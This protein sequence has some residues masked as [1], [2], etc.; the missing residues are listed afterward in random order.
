M[1]IKM[2]LKNLIKERNKTMYSLSKETNIPYSTINDYCNEK[3]DLKKCSAET[4]YKISQALSVSMESLISQDTSKRK[5]ALI[6]ADAINSIE[7]AEVSDYSYFLSELWAEGII[8][9][10][11]LKQAMK[12]YHNHQVKKM[13]S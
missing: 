3:K 12:L 9:D 6:F 7:G 13:N 8:T 10:S 4:L 1:V 2:N 11:G 5:E